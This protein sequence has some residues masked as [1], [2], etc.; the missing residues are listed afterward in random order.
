[1]TTPLP[2]AADPAYLTTALRKAGGLGSRAVSD[3]TVLSARDIIVSRIIRLGLRYDGPAPDAP[4]TLILKVA[5]ENF[6]RTLWQAGRQ[7]VAFY[8]EIAPQLPTQLVPR[9]FDSL[10]DGES[11]VWHLLLEDLTD[12]HDIASAWPLPPTA[13]QAAAIVQTL[14]RLHATWWDDPRLGRSVG[15][16]MEPAAMEQLMA[17][18]A[19]HFERFAALLG[20]RLS[21]A[22]RD[23]Y[24]RF[25]SATPKLLERY[26]SRRDLTI[27][28]GDAHIWNFLVPKPEV[29]D[30][31]RVFDF[32]QW[33]INVG[34]NDLAYMIALQLYPERRRG[35]EGQLLDRYHAALIS[36][37]VTGYSRAALDDDYRRAV[38]WHITKPVWQWT[39][40]IPPVIWWNNLERIFL[41]VDDLGCLE[42]LE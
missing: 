7:E 35:I 23:V 30:R 4:A 37:G 38:L 6:V 24:R 26:H 39:V 10:W 1:M 2:P 8:R 27:V 25:M 17:Q 28:H 20:D 33:R 21:A 40:Q 11:H 16:F 14:A 18:F 12:T 41:A 42:L 15:S 29:D 32:D 5:Q 13:E 34:A 19:G 36:H 31:V 9:C 3:V 22:Q